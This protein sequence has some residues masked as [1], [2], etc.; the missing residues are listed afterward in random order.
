M[1]RKNQVLKVRLFADGTASAFTDAQAE[2]ISNN[3]NRL[4]STIDPNDVQSVSTICSSDSG[5]RMAIVTVVY[6]ALKGE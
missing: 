6:Y 4:L 2:G 5:Y 1:E 3:A